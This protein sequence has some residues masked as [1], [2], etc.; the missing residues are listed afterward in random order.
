MRK[1]EM[2]ENLDPL[3]RG[4]HSLKFR[5]RETELSSISLN[6]LLPEEAVLIE[7]PKRIKTTR[8]TCKSLELV[9][10]T[11]YQLENF[12]FQYLHNFPKSWLL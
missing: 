7:S 5:R 6:H 8:D 10:F 4:S 11:T 2:P 1:T 12:V 3:K 9:I